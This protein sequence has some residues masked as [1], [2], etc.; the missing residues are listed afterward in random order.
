MDYSSVEKVA[1]IYE[2]ALEDVINGLKSL[3]EYSI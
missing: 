1:S 2:Y 3:K